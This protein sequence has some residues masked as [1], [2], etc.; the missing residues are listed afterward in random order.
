MRA[1]ELTY[2]PRKTEIKN[3]I[4]IGEVGL[5]KLIDEL[6]SDDWCKFDVKEP[7][8]VGWRWEYFLSDT[9]IIAMTC[10]HNNAKIKDYVTLVAPLKSDLD[11][12][13]GL[14]DLKYDKI[15]K[16]HGNIYHTITN[17]GSIKI[18]PIFHPAVATYN[19]N[20]KNILLED[21]KIIKKAVEQN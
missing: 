17:L 12:L 3:S 19:P 14:L 8:N 11:M 6:D 4:D 20:K 13:A 7:D 15:T 10:G 1:Y 21:F 2:T 9:G 18:I 5:T 16:V